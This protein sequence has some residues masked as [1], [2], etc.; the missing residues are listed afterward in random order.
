MSRFLVSALLLM[1][2]HGTPA[3]VVRAATTKRNVTLVL[4][5]NNV[6]SLGRQGHPPDPQAVK[7][8]GVVDS[9]SACEDLYRLQ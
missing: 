8:L 1:A 9:F 2:G 4:N 3:A 5:S 7:L 6:A